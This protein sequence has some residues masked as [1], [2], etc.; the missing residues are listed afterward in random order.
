MTSPGNGFVDGLV[1]GM[2]R[3][4]PLVLDR[5]FQTTVE[6][7]EH[8]PTDRPTVFVANHGSSLGLDALVLANH[9]RRVSGRGVR[10]LAHRRWFQNAT[11]RRLMADLEIEEAR[12]YPIRRALEDGCSLIVFP[13]A[14]AGNFKTPD[15]RYHLMRFHAGFLHEAHRCQAT[16][17]PVALL[18]PEDSTF[19]L[20]RLN[21]ER[22]FLRAQIPLVINPVP[23]PVPWTL[24]FLSP[25]FA[26]EQTCGE[27]EDRER[28]AADIRERLQLELDQMLSDRSA[29]IARRFGRIRIDGA[30]RLGGGRVSI[31]K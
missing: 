7:S 8:V 21:L 28:F 24:R 27:R 25:A 22:T 31:K 6:G 10:V 30:H 5:Y 19:N 13:E 1:R 16:L 12:L 2:K 14:E 3:L 4:V 18:G 29:S 20:G 9:A 15:Q 11:L 26:D 17:I 23:L